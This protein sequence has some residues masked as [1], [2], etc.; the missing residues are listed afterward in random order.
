MAVMGYREENGLVVLTMTQDDFG[1]LLYSIGYAGGNSR[2]K[3][4]EYFALANRLNAGN[5]NFTPYEMP[6]EETT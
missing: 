3:W 6:T 1:L 4:L 5:P 2:G